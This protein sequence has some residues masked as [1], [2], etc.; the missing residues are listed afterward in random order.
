MA[1]SNGATGKAGADSARR[2]PQRPVVPAI[3]LPYLQRKGRASRQGPLP[4]A[5]SVP[6]TA[7]Q[8]LPVDGQQHET[9]SPAQPD[10][11]Q[12]EQKL[13]T[14]TDRDGTADLG[15][16]STSALEIEAVTPSVKPAKPAAPGAPESPPLTASSQEGFGGKF[17]VYL[18]RG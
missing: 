6:A 12:D 1:P 16:N 11:A 13:S 15:N 8:S 5:S 17:L 10:K 4:E 18:S 9:K 3:P 2:Q 14:G 7:E